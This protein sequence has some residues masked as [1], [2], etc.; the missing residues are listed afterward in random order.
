MPPLRGGN[1]NGSVAV[2]AALVSF[3]KNTNDATSAMKEFNSSV[4]KEQAEVDYLFTKLKNAKK[5]TD[6]YKEALQQL[7]D[8][9]PEVMAK[10]I[11]EKG[12]LDDINQAYQDII[13]SIRSKI[14]MDMKEKQITAANEKALEEQMKQLDRARKNIRKQLGNEDLADMVVDDLKRMLDSGS[15]Q[16]IRKLIKDSGI[17]PNRSV[18]MIDGQLGTIIGKYRRAG[19]EL[20]NQIEDISKAYDPFIQK[21]KTELEEMYDRL[22]QLQSA[23]YAAE[24]KEPYKNQ[25]KELREKIRLKEEESKISQRESENT[26]T[27]TNGNSSSSSEDP[28]AD[29]EKKLA[30][31][32]KRQQNASL[33]GWAKTKQGIIDSYQE[34]IDEANKLGKEDVAKQLTGERDSAI[35]VAGEKYMNKMTNMLVEFVKQA[36][37]LK[38]D[39]GEESE[40]SRIIVGTNEEWERRL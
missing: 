40:L 22:K 21:T 13:Q 15:D 18:S 23:Y 7:I 34:M 11:D 39:G 38:A 33:E 32:R 16:E 8:K 17:D 30:D 20:K 29:F 1:H 5:G 9:Y 37:T 12:R 14:A 19:Y 26:S 10:H 3:I 31:F 27:T 25:I 6:D 24:D 36:E 28:I 35:K 4:A 2:G